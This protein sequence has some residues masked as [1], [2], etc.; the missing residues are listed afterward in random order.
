MVVYTS[1]Q[2]VWASVHSLLR[3]G[4]EKLIPLIQKNQDDCVE[5]LFITCGMVLCKKDHQ[6]VHG[7]LGGVF[8]CWLCTSRPL[9]GVLSTLGWIDACISYPAS[10]GRYKERGWS[11]IPQELLRSWKPQRYILTGG[12]IITVLV[13]LMILK[14]ISH[15]QSWNQ[16]LNS[17]KRCMKIF[18]TLQ[19]LRCRNQKSGM[20]LNKITPLPC[21]YKFLTKWYIT[22]VSR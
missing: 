15:S 14:S 2:L 10:H 16:T 12:L 21:H 20:M 1:V 18:M 13:M 19:V 22:M 17:T 5:V 9:W 7:K 8:E 3:N 4:V 11:D 6:T